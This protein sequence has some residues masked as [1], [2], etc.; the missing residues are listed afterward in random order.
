MMRIMMVFLSFILLTG[1]A[2]VETNQSNKDSQ[3]E[4]SPT[5]IQLE[6]KLEATQLEDK[7][8]FDLTLTNKGSEDVELTYSSG[9]QFEITM[10]DE[11]SKEIYRYSEGKMF[12]QALVTEVI[13]AGEQLDWSIEWDQKTDG[14]RLVADGN[15]TVTAEVLAKTSDESTTI[16]T[17]QLQHTISMSIENSDTSQEKENKETGTDEVKIEDLENK[18]FRNIKVEGE[19]GEYTVTGEARVFEGVFGYSVSDGHQYFIEEFKQVDEGAPNW[20]AFTLE[21]SISE[22]ELP[23]NGT[24]ML[25]LYEE[26]AKDGSKVNELNVPLD[27]IKK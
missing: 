20:S 4:E 26:S 9:Q 5:T 3:E 8:V 13:K 11:D 10:K 16:D 25:E 22:D 21:I 12:T 24:V 6:T 17:E 27:R 7:V 18:A 2:T 19:Y 1:C 23:V 14:S 15:Y